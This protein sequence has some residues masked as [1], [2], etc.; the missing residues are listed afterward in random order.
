MPLIF[1]VNMLVHTDEGDT[2]T[3]GEMSALASRGRLRQ[4]AAA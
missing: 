2:F 3:F 1:A 4:P